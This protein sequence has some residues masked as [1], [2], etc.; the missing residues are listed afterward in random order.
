MKRKNTLANL[1]VFI[2]L[3]GGVLCCPSVVFA[4]ASKPEQELHIA[5]PIITEETMPNEY[6]EWD[7]RMSGS[8]S[9]RGAEG[10]GFLPRS[11]LFF[12]FANRWGGEIDVPLAFANQEPNYYG[13]GDISATVKY[14]LLNP[15]VGRPGFVLG[16][17][18]TF[19]SGNTHNGLGE[20]VFEAAPF[21]A[22][23]YASPPM[24]LQGN[25]GYSVVHRVRAT[26]A[27]DQLSYNAAVI[28]PLERLHTDLVEEI[29]GTR[30]R[31]GNRVAFS[32]GLKYNL[33]AQRFLAIALP[34]GLTSRTPRLGIVLQLQIALRS[35]KKDNGTAK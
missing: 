2:V 23:V 13:I 28:F 7:L 1:C 19:P 20:G 33:S 12:G 29:N 26:E 9:W 11:Q 15:R 21:V 17:E 24:I 27:S 25:F 14:L 3:T 35:P 10:F 31:N 5:E 6:G 18:T 32:T 16:L 30:D 22:V 8:Y 34:V 4:Q